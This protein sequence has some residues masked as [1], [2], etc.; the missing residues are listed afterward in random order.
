MR[1]RAF[2]NLA[3]DDER[4]VA[5]QRPADYRFSVY[6]GIDSLEYATRRYKV[7]LGM[8][9]DIAARAVRHFRIRC[10]QSARFRERA[11][12]CAEDGAYF[13]DTKEIVED[14]ARGRSSRALKRLNRAHR[15]RS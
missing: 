1:L 11:M 12:K 9:A 15:A 8:T 5:Q 6:T 4:V 13:D 2:E 7:G 3:T 14:L 10:E